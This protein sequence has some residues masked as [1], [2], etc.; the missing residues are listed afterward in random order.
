MATKVT[1]RAGILRVSGGPACSSRRRGA[2]AGSGVGEHLLDDFAVCCRNIAT[3]IMD[4]ASHYIVGEVRLQNDVLW[5]HMHL[6]KE[7]NRWKGI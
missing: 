6:K 1:Q 7:E 3:C 4:V 5:V 2:G